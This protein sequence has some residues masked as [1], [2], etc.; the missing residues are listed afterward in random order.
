[1]GT[2][3]KVEGQH[4][5]FSSRV[6]YLD[7]AAVKRGLSDKSDLRIDLAENHTLIVAYFELA[8]ATVST[9]C[10]EQRGTLRTKVGL[11]ARLY[12]ESEN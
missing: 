10:M 5:W 12:G 7:P 1:M 4:E 8:D 3:R 2:L 6:R 11:A 9:I